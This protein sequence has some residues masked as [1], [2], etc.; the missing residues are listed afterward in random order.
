MH[1]GVTK[2]IIRGSLL[3]LW[4]L[5]L[6]DFAILTLLGGLYGWHSNRIAA[7]IALS[8][9]LATSMVHIVTLILVR[10]K[11]SAGFL[12]F[13]AL[14]FVI[15]LV[16]GPRVQFLE[17]QL[18]DYLKTP[19]IFSQ[20]KMIK[21]VQREIDLNQLPFVIDIKKSKRLTYQNREIVIVLE[22]SKIEELQK[23]EFDQIRA[24]MYGRKIILVFSD[25]SGERVIRIELKRDQ[26]IEYC[27]PELICNEF[28]IEMKK[29]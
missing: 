14:I 27:S 22:K 11:F 25:N 8:L 16:N 20:N 28:G 3:I 6:V 15:L 7:L 18:I 26:T 10:K 2:K 9:T 5:F 29:E 13:N 19:T 24:G 23:E 21:E 1:R 4:G 17:M 12:V